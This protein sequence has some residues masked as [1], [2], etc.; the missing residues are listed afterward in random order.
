MTNGYF[1]WTTRI[2]V[3]ET[4]QTD[5]TSVRAGLARRWEPMPSGSS[6]GMF[7]AC[8]ELSRWWSNAMLK[9]PLLVSLMAT[10]IELPPWLHGAADRLKDAAF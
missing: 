6:A 5:I 8:L 7:V 1:K 2:V 10:E 4:F 3:Y 9:N